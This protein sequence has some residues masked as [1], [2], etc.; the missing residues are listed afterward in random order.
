M[1][2]STRYHGVIPPVITPRASDGSIDTRSLE[3]TVEHLLTG[4]V[5][6]LF[7]LGSSGEV[8]YMTGF[9]RDQV[10]KIVTSAAAGQVPVLAGANEQTTARVIEEGQRAVAQGVE[11]LV[12]TSPYYALPNEQETESHFRAVAAAVGVP[13]FAYDVPVRTHYKLSTSMLVRLGTDGVL[14]GVK[15]S[16][17]DDVAFRELVLAARNIPGFDIFTGHEVVAD[18]ALLGGADGVVPGLGNVDPA[19][20]ARMYAASV[21][22]DWNAVKAEQDRLA[23]LFRIVYAPTPGRVSGGAAGLG[24]FKTALVLMGI[25]STNTMSVPMLALNDEETLTIRNILEQAGLL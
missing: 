15:D 1:S 4:G 3:R 19:G 11:A 14:A 5:D 22:G 18:G 2:S 25:I 17:G 21:R 12:V 16:S 23:D 8:P 20:Y 24:A 13:V 9:E 6:G 7:I 10:V